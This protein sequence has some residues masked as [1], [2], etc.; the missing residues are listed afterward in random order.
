M[1]PP[2]SNMLNTSPPGNGKF[3]VDR[4]QLG[5]ETSGVGKSVGFHQIQ[6]QAHPLHRGSPACSRTPAQ[7]H[8]ECL[9]ALLAC[10]SNPSLPLAP[11]GSS[12]SQHTYWNAASYRKPSWLALNQSPLT[13]SGTLHSLGC[14]LHPCSR[15]CHLASL[16]RC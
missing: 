2:P 13:F 15:Y 12:E 5:P 9:L 6:T 3:Q 11:F 4:R 7:P 1:S 16:P 10:L 14:P 8:A